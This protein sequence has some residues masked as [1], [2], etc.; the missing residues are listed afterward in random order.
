MIIALGLLVNKYWAGT[1]FLAKQAV[2]FVEEIFGSVL[3]ISY[4]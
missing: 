3:G 2:F 1:Q 4:I